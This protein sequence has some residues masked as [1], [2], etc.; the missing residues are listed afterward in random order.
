MRRVTH[1]RL[2]AR[3]CTWFPTTFW[4]PFCRRVQTRRAS[5]SILLLLLDFVNTEFKDCYLGC[6]SD[7]QL[8]VRAAAGIRGHS[9]PCACFFLRSLCFAGMYKAKP[10]LACR[11][12]TYMEQRAVGSITDWHWRATDK[13]QTCKHKRNV[14][15]LSFL[16]L[17]VCLGTPPALRVMQ[18]VHRWCGFLLLYSSGTFR[19]WRMHRKSRDRRRTVEHVFNFLCFEF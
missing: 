7:T 1:A 11:T 2:A 16:A 13:G 4:F 14:F 10:P 5:H 6:V 19:C 3:A 17:N 8:Y 15:F 9:R 18:A 12:T